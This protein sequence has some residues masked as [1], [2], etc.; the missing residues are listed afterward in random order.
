MLT[1]E[2]L[3]STD[4]TLRKACREIDINDPEDLKFAQVLIGHMFRTLYADP[5]GVALASPQVGLL[6]CVTVISFDDQEA[7]E[8]RLMA[9]IN[10]KII[11]Y[12]DETTAKNEICLS[13][14][15]Q[16]GKV[17]RALQVDVEAYD[18]HGRPVAFCAEGFFARVIQHELDHLNG[19]LY[20]DRVDD[21]LETV[22]DFPERRV[23]PA[24]AQLELP[25]LQ[26]VRPVDS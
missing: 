11:R 23:I 14:P 10:P 12:S 13:A 3:Y 20:I 15:N 21:K 17:V 9:L 5:S 4:S 2:L 25:S 24:L 7:D 1:E 8:T 6:V 26:Q 16:T 19:I 22:P 18:Q